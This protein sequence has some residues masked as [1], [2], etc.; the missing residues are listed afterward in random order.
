MEKVDCSAEIEACYRRQDRFPLSLGIQLEEIRAGYA[1]V[2]ME[3]KEEMT[4]FHGIT[5][6]GALFALA[7][8]AFGL[9]SNT[10]GPAVAL[11]VSINFIKA[12]RPGDRLTATAQEEYL[13]RS[14]GIYQISVTRGE[15]LVALIRGT[16]FRKG[17]RK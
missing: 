4:N 15:E 9:A 5:H 8:T 16:V 17:P 10:R 3:I 13:T 6:G 11:Q 1:R 14:T 12:T 2:S 7:D